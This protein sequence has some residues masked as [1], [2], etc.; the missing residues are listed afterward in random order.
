MKTDTVH[1][2]LLRRQSEEGSA[3]T[4]V[5]RG[6]G[7]HLILVPA[8]SCLEDIQ[9]QREFIAGCE[10]WLSSNEAR[11]MCGFVRNTAG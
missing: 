7:S 11:R 9:A 10:T 6:R 2:F 8:G 5:I 4:G 1:N 3:T